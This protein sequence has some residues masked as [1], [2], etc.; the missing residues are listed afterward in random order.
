[1]SANRKMVDDIFAVLNQLNAAIDLFLAGKKRRAREKRDQA[2]CNM[3]DLVAKLE[4]GA[5]I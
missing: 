2:V 1:M 3:R 4:N 5:D